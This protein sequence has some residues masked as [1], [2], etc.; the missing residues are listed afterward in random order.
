M[1]GCLCAAA[2]RRSRTSCATR[3]F[4]LFIRCLAT[5]KTD[6]LAPIGLGAHDFWQSILPRHP[7]KTN[8]IFSRYPPG[9]HNRIR[10][11][12]LY[13]PTKVLTGC[14]KA[15]PKASSDL[16]LESFLDHN[17]Y[18][19]PRHQNQ[20]ALYRVSDNRRLSICPIGPQMGAKGSHFLGIGFSGALIGCK[21]SRVLYA[22]KNQLEFGFG[23][24]P[25]ITS[26]G[27]PI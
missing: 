12:L 13:G 7:P 5:R 9:K 20:S 15:I 6:N 19:C 8:R 17:S 22:L 3:H 25:S 4:S 26:N 1:R 2:I 23:S 14:M 10:L 11:P 18:Q 27:A 24:E 16:N 21:P